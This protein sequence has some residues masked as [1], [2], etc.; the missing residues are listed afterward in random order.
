MTVLRVLGVAFWCI[1]VVLFLVHML[2]PQVQLTSRRNRVLT[3]GEAIVVLLG[4]I[5]VVLDSALMH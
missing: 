3:A 2:I 1:A 4:T 5:L